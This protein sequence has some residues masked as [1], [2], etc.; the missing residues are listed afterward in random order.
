M[1]D[2]RACSDRGGGCSLSVAAGIILY[3]MSVYEELKD[4]NTPACAQKKISKAQTMEPR[5][6]GGTRTLYTRRSLVGTR[7]PS[8]K[9][10][11]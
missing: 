7:V 2:A 8:G 1:N 3:L 11:R 6:R 5:N 10:T 4:T 9:E